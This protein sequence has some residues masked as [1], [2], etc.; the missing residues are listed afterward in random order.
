MVNPRLVKLFGTTCYK[1]YAYILLY[2]YITQIF[3]YFV[4]PARLEYSQYSQLAGFL[5]V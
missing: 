4:L 3:V 1:A 5:L 2:W